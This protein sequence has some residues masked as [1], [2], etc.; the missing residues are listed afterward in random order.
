MS[1]VVEN[2]LNTLGAHPLPVVLAIALG[3]AWIV[4]EYVGRSSTWRQGA[5]RRPPSTIDRGTYPFIAVALAIGMVSTMFSFFLGIGGYFPLWTTAVGVALMVIGLATRLWALTTLGR[6]FTMPITLSADHRIV[7]DGPYRWL[8]H[9]SYSGGFLTAVGMPLVLGT[10][11]GLV[12][13]VLA[14]A[15]AYVYRIRI[16][17]AALV[18]R[19]GESYR[20][21]SGKTWRLIPGIY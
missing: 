10:P 13:T 12:I 5:P 9:P 11:M 19:F 7:R 15:T 21:Y 16:E 4:A 6:F 20:E 18:A 1:S 3:L 14:C 8:R 17:E 2:A